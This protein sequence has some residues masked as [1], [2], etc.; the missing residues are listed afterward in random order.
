M[1]S[2]FLNPIVSIWSRVQGMPG[3]QKSGEEPTGP[4]SF[5]NLKQL[6][7]LAGGGVPAKCK[8][9]GRGGA[10]LLSRLRTNGSGAC[11]SQE[12]VDAANAVYQQIQAL[13]PKN[14]NRR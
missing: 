12:G 7:G 14:G 3:S 11:D 10:T 8:K 4:V 6:A 5:A 13:G 2:L 9:R 1:L